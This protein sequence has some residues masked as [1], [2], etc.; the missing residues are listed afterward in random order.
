MIPGV[1][2]HLQIDIHPDFEDS[3]LPDPPTCVD[4][5]YNPTGYAQLVYDTVSW[6]H[7][8]CNQ[9]RYDGYRYQRYLFSDIFIQTDDTG[10]PEWWH[11]GGSSYW[12]VNTIGGDGLPSM[13]HTVDGN[14]APFNFPWETNIPAIEIQESGIYAVWANVDFVLTWDAVE[15]IRFFVYSNNSKVILVNMKE[16]DEPL[17]LVPAGATFITRNFSWY[18]QVYLKKWEYL[19]LGLRVYTPNPAW[20][21]TLTISSQALQ[22]ADPFPTSFA[23]PLS[24]TTFGCCLISKSTQDAN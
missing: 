16:A 14:A 15:A 22:L 23:G 17:P 9:N 12:F 21:F 4:A 18:N 13:N 24:G 1:N 6:V 2:E 20:T 10:F 8:E 5:D 11:V 7:R 19:F 3:I